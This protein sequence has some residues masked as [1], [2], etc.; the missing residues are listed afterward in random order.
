MKRLFQ[1][2]NE[3]EAL[4]ILNVCQ[5]VL[6][7]YNISFLIEEVT[8]PCRTSDLVFVRAL[9]SFY[10]RK[11]GLPYADIALILKRKSHA[12]I[13]SLMDYDIKGHSQ[14]SIWK[15]I[16]GSMTDEETKFEIQEKI[17]WH[18]EQIIKLTKSVKDDKSN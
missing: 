10:L 17:K 5:Y 6:S 4:F 14:N 12:T 3:E 9:I 1:K 13:M 7:K 15:S 2:R 8:S 11:R 18:Q 16:T